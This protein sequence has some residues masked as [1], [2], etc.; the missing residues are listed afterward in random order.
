MNDLT[1]L[2]IERNGRLSFRQS[3]AATAAEVDGNF[4]QVCLV[5]ME[6]QTEISL[7]LSPSFSPLPFSTF[8]PGEHKKNQTDFEPCHY[9][10]RGETGFL[11]G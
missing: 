1:T 11:K 6:L 9:H 4:K 7:S 8:F 10:V 2:C 3:A 5:R